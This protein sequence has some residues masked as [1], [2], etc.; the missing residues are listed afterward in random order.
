MVETPLPRD[1]AALT[2]M[3]ATT[4]TP[5]S[6]ETVAGHMS[7]MSQRRALLLLRSVREGLH[8]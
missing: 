5:I 2:V 7:I 8:T 6:H 4:T 1:D 3:S